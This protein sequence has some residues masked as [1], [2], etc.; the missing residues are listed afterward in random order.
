M[1][2]NVSDVKVIG[3][4]G[5]G[6]NCIK[7]LANQGIKKVDLIMANTDKKALK[8]DDENLNVAVVIL[9][10]DL[11]CAE[12]TKGDPE[13]GYEAAMES[14]DELKMLLKGAGMVFIRAGMGG[15]TGSGA[16]V[17]AAEIA[18]KSGAM[19]VALVNM[20]SF[21][22]GRK[23]KDVA[24]QW[25]SKLKQ[26]VDGMA[27]MPNDSLLQNQ[28]GNKSFSAAL[29]EGDHYFKDI[30]KSLNCFLQQ[31]GKLLCDFIKRNDLCLIGAGKDWGTDGLVSA[32]KKA[33]DS[34]RTLNDVEMKDIKHVLAVIARK[35]MDDSEDEG[36]IDGLI[37]GDVIVDV[38]WI[39]DEELE[40]DDVRVVVLGA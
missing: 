38:V 35:R 29:Q 28:S 3:I 19:T 12:G 39:E 26:I 33:I 31:K 34:L 32:V 4:G 16:S 27:I 30:I 36:V 6:C 20:P 5:A 2:T 13:L 11:D 7:Y 9:G 1:N 14:Y 10:E 24:E 15:G 25:L 21:F 22:E 37:E 23:R 40:D 18:K 8:P 17:V